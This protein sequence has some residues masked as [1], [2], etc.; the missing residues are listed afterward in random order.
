V[1]PSQPLDQIEV[2]VAPARLDDTKHNIYY[3]ERGVR[4]TVPPD[5]LILR[6]V[7]ALD[8]D[9]D[10]SVVTFLSTYGMIGAFF[11]DP[12]TP[13][14]PVKLARQMLSDLAL[15]ARH[16]IGRNHGD[17]VVP[18]WNATPDAVRRFRRDVGAVVGAPLDESACDSM[19]VEML[20]R[21]LSELQ[22]HVE[23]GVA[24]RPETNLYTALC[25]QLHQLIF[26]DL[27]V[28]ECA[29]ETCRQSFTRQRGTAQHGQ[30]RTGGVRFCSRSCAR[31]QTERER[32]RRN[33]SGGAKA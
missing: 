4:R 16:Y 27:P 8:T 2:V 12:S 33:R 11:D 22:V 32:R 15:M 3:D 6:E 14:T 18:L 19:F 1:W 13:Y 20:N 29:N 24:G 30:Y 9:D 25:L 17:D 21:G 5:E 7:I 31:A 26:D 23:L 28:L 10:D